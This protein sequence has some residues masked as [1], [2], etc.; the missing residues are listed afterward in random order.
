MPQTRYVTM[1]AL[2]LGMRPIVI[3]NKVDRPNAEPSRALDK[4]LD[5]FIELG[6]SDDQI[7]FPVLY[8]SGL[9]GWL[10]RDLA[11]DKHEGMDHLFETI[12]EHVPSPKADLDAPFL[13][14]VSSIGWRDHI[15]R[16]ACGRV[17]QGML[18]KGPAFQRITTDWIDT[19]ARDE[20]QVVET[21]M[22]RA[23]YIWATRGLDLIE[24]DEASAGDIVWVAGPKEVNIG[25][26]FA[27]PEL[28]NAAQAP[29]EIEEPTVSMLFLVNSGPF[30]GQDGRAATIRELRDRLARELRT[31]VALR[32]EEIN[33]ADGVKVSG[34]G[35]LHLAI[36]IEEMR[37]E[38]M[39]LC[40]SAPEIITHKDSHG[41]TLEPYEEVIIDIPMDFQGSVME[42]LARRKGDMKNLFMERDNAI[43]L[44]FHIPT[45]GLLGYRT[46][47]LTDTRGLGIM[48][49]RFIG[50]YPWAGEIASR[51]KGSMISMDQGDATA[52]S[53]EN[54]QER[55]TLFI[56]P[57]TPVYNGMIIGESSRPGDFPCNP[58]KAKKLT[59][60][61]SATKDMTTTL[62][63]PRLLTLD[64]A[65][66]W[67]AQD[68]LVEVTPKNV[69]MRKAILD[70][71]MRKREEKRQSSL[72]AS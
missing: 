17:Q 10:V 28:Q 56:K 60:H 36:L 13:M 35:E 50:Y 11:K 57:M 12:I 5:L 47:F 63:V 31:N 3:I 69:R 27:A 1:R 61:R 53:L 37:R 54:L 67:I 26:T 62:D 38:G 22:E 39:E 45:R 24:V 71:E 42:K 7:D 58:T 64:T 8:G 30:S 6:A 23:N 2:K 51:N 66:E 33:R 68:E 40:V 21:T 34:R 29:L 15:G 59:N 70:H 18:R 20:F 41:K 16:I 48:T 43:R 65:L 55:G 72:A 25:D 32:V 14:Q 19:L 46:E 44:E 49:S 4:T 52:Y 9:N